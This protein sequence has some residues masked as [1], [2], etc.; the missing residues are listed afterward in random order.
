MP[1][2]ASKTN[3]ARQAC[4]SAQQPAWE[5]GI[6]VNDL[7]DENVLIRSN[8]DIAVMDPVPMME[9]TSKIKRIMEALKP[10]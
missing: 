6:E 7:H 1:G 2:R 4:P 8:G 5:A 9:E 10:S 3:P